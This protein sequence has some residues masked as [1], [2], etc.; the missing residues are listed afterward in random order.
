M[1][2]LNLLR[3]L[4]PHFIMEELEE[5]FKTKK[6]PH[7]GKPITI[8][9]YNKVKE[10]VNNPDKIKKHSFLPFIH[11]T[12]LK[13]KFRADKNNSERN[14]CGKR[15]RI[16]DK[17]K[18]RPIFF[19]SHLDAMIF[20]KYNTV[21]AE[22]YEKH[23]EKKPFNESIVAYRK[24]PVIKGQK[25]NKCNIDFAKSAFEYIKANKDK[26]LTVIVADITSFFDNLN[27]K[28][29]K[30]KWTEVIQETTLPPDH[31]NL[32]KALVRIRYVESQQLFKAYNQTMIVERGV[33]NS[34]TRKK[35]VRK[36]INSTKYFKEKNAVAYCEK[37]EFLK[38]NLG[39][40]I[41]KDN[42]TGIPQGSP[43][44]ATLANI[45][46]LDFDEKIFCEIEN[47]H[48]FYQR[49][50]DDL[51]IVFEQ[52]YEDDIIKLLRKTI[53]GDSVKLNIEPRKTKLF[54]FEMVN[55]FFRGFA[56]DEITKKPNN[57]KSLEYLGFSFD[58]QRVL[59]KNAG[60][61]KFYRSMKGSF[62]RAVSYAMYSKNPD[63]SLFK[64]R[65]YKRF[66]YK[67]AKRKLIYRPSKHNPK[68]YIKTKEYNWGNYLSYVYKADDSMKTINGNNAIKKQSGNLWGE[69]HRLMKLHEKKLSENDL[70]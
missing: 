25:G 8:K 56:V 63:K 28:I 33:P 15:Q 51:I 22:S 68:V 5:W 34:S 29:L 54:H 66:T 47:K 49:Y 42:K 24:I 35:Y 62:N 69:F 50:S 67:G 21:L 39:L 45:Y 70:K 4:P 3:N 1:Y 2:V 46:M 19:A 53:S 57:N 6:Y 48:G 27:H 41:S 18:V 11:K 31:Y 40:I 44:S 52:K 32:F 23:I 59:I 58:G 64:S 12:I 17:P 60:F 26:K 36:K 16:K 30:K 14:P 20:S 7:I 13:R 43:I 65:L 10:Y 61:S 9:D 37:D 55:G 38:N